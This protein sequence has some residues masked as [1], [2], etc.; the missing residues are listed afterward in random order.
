M[1]T[2]MLTRSVRTAADLARV[3]L[4]QAEGRALTIFPPRSVPPVSRLTTDPVMLAGA[5]EAG[6][7][8]ALDTFRAT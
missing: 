7:E 2:A 5:L 8:A 3:E 1:R 6:R 4:A